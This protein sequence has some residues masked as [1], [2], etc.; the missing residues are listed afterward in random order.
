[1]ACSCSPG[2]ES[3]R[4][5]RRP[6]RASLCVCDLRLTRCMRAQGR[7]RTVAMCESSRGEVIAGINQFL[8]AGNPYQVG[9]RV[10]WSC[11][12]SAWTAAA[13]MVRESESVSCPPTCNPPP[14]PPHPP[15]HPL[16][17][18]GHSPSPTPTQHTL[19]PHHLVRDLPPPRCALCGLPPLLRP[20]HV[21]RGPPPQ[22]RRHTHVQ[23]AGLAAVPATGE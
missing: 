18:P 8:G 21:R 2:R 23:G 14:I 9:G 3:R 1:M 16:S 13:A 15:P 7:V 17:P 12:I 20:P 11:S 5:Q 6:L 4:G 10:R 19:G 22:E